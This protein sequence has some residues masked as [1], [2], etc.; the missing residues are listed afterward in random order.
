MNQKVAV[1]VKS[2]YYNFIPKVIPKSNLSYEDQNTFTKE[3]NVLRQLNHP[4][5]VKFLKFQETNTH[6]Y[7]VMELVPGGDLKALMRS[8]KKLSKPL[9]ESEVSKILWRVLLAVKYIHSKGI[10]HRD[11]K[12]GKKAYNLL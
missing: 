6:M 8:R 10:A 4:N 5:I 9:T 2:A 3:A 1:K 11:L 7:I 12:L